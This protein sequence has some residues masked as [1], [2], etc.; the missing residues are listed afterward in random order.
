MPT[1]PSYAKLLTEGF[2]LQPGDA[3]ERT[4]MEGGLAKQ[5]KTR[6]RVLVARPVIYAFD[7]KAD[8]ESFRTWVKTD[9]NR[10][11]SWFTWTDPVDATAKNARIIGGRLASIRPERPDLGSWRIQFLLETFDG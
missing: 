9:L 8:M 5:A 3:V 2:E 4:D 1:F 10:G 6:S 11:A 7:S